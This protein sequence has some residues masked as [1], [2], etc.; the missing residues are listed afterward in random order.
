MSIEKLMDYALELGLLPEPQ[1]ETFRAIL[2]RHAFS[3][4]LK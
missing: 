1:K 3:H 4:Y 2:L